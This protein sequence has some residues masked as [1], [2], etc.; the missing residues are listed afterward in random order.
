[1]SFL[2][3]LL[4]AKSQRADPKALDDL[5]IAEVAKRAANMSVP[6]DTNH[7]L[8]LPTEEAAKAVA[9]AVAQPG[10]NVKARPAATGSNWLVL[11]NQEMVVS[12]ATIADVRREFSA[13]V[14][15]YGGDYDGWEAAAT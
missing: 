6:R 4:G 15:P 5:T 10:R 8:Y 9:A 13:A 12:D 11:V 7:Y 3:R 14:A 2:K 1:V